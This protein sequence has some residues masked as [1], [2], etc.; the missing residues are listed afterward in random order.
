MTTL[1]PLIWSRTGAATYCTQRGGYTRRGFFKGENIPQS[2]WYSLGAI[3]QESVFWRRSLWDKAGAHLDT[4]YPLA[5]D[6]ELWARFFQH[7]ELYTVSVPLGGFRVHGNQRSIAQAEKYRTE[8]ERVLSTYKGRS[9]G[10]IEAIVVKL[11]KDY[12]RLPYALRRKASL[13]GLKPT[14]KHCAYNP[15]LQSWES[16]DL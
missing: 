4:T 14:H 9:M 1:C 7:A 5:A 10:K 6:F 15:T 13:W 3:Q 8:V 12:L 11:T 16:N 2:H